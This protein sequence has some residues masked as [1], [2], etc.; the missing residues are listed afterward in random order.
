MPT[1]DPAPL[2][3]GPRRLAAR[4]GFVAS[5]FAVFACGWLAVRTDDWRRMLVYSVLALVAASLA[6]AF[7]RRSR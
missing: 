4:A 5:A 7:S 3:G 6:S 1:P 2:G